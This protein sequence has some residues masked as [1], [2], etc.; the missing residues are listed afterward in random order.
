MEYGARPPLD[1]DYTIDYCLITKGGM[2]GGFFKI[3]SNQS[4]FFSPFGK[5]DS[6]NRQ[7]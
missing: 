7:R 2:K 3:N 1:N 4:P 5:G 6:L